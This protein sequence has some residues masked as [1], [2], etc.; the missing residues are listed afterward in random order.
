MVR[1]W[2][3]WLKTGLPP[4]VVNLLAKING[5]QTCWTL[6]FL[7]ITPGELC[8][9]TTRHFIPSQRTLM[10][11]KKVL[12]LIRDQQPHDS[13]NK[14]TLSFTKRNCC[15]CVKCYRWHLLA[16]AV[17]LQRLRLPTWHNHKVSPVRGDASY[18]KL[19]WPLLLIIAQHTWRHIACRTW[20]DCET[21]DSHPG[22]SDASPVTIDKL[23]FSYP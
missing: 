15:N 16:A 17:A 18:C 21:S 4:D 10:E 3:S 7:N 14:A 8:L 1:C 13:I 19:L 9:N 11:W 5:H 12:Q 23:L 2:Q 20:C 22:Q 6:A